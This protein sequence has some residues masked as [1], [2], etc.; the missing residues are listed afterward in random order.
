MSAPAE[1][2]IV[3]AAVG[4]VITATNE[5]LEAS[6]DIPAVLVEPSIVR[7]DPA[8]VLLAASVPIV[9]KPEPVMFSVVKSVAVNVVTVTAPVLEEA[10]LMVS[11]LLAVNAVKVVA[12]KPVTVNALVVVSINR[13]IVAVEPVAVFA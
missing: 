4:A 2:S 9:T 13:V 1:P 11:S 12:V 5:E 7:T 6:T 8:E 10:K 3:L